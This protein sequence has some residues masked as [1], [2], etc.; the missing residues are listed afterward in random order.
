MIGENPLRAIDL[1][2]RDE[3]PPT[4]T[5]P[6]S[7]IFCQL[8]DR[9]AA[10]IQEAQARR[11]YF[12]DKHRREEEFE[13]GDLVWVSTR[14]MQP[15]GSPKF[16]PKSVGQLKVQKRVGKVAYRLD[17]PLSMKQHPVFHVALLLRHK[18]RPGYMRA[19]DSWGP[20]DLKKQDE[21][22]VEHL[23]D[24]RGSGPNEELL[25]KWR[26]FPKEE[27]TW[28]PI[29]NLENSKALVQALQVK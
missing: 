15:R 11:K 2:L 16:Q 12:A 29:A 8:V 28:E 21:W 19:E 27:A 9:A 24:R 17:L 10:H 25:V 1:D 4:C 22:E 18:P 13:V 7:K 20:L 6:M 14:Y 23:L 5:P 3:L 26:G